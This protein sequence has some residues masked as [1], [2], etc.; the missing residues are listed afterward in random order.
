MDYQ[1]TSVLI[2][3]DPLDRR[4]DLV[5]YL[6]LL[7]SF[8]WIIA[9]GVAIGGALGF[10]YTR[11]TPATYE[12]TARLLI[13]QLVGAAVTVD[14]QNKYLALVD[15]PT[16]AAQVVKDAALDGPPLHLTPSRLEAA[17][18]ARPGAA[19]NIILIDVRLPDADAAARA[20]A[21]A[22]RRVAELAREQ[23]RNATTDSQTAIRAELAEADRL[24][25]V[26]R[27][28]LVTFRQTNNAVEMA[29]ADLDASTGDRKKLQELLGEQAANRARLEDAERQ[30]AQTQ[31]TITLRRP[32]VTGDGREVAGA[33]Q[34]NVEVVNPAYSA[35]H[36]RVQQLRDEIAGG[37]ARIAYLKGSTP[38]T[39][40]RGAQIASVSEYETKLAQLQGEVARAQRFRDQL[41]DASFQLLRESILP[42]YALRFVEETLPPGRKVSPITRNYVASGMAAGLIVSI[43]MVL[44][45]ASRRGPSSQ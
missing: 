10:V 5:G 21:S 26:A 14:V 33:P 8:A 45:L 20:A 9:I 37:D 15:D 29:R 30:L 22:G 32:V 13:G 43:V 12:A 4:I 44:A 38:S 7:R 36:A 18:T 25:A 6:S 31:P 34:A 39:A 1:R 28:A 41:G 42:R 19:N 27:E 23:D 35:L 40:D 2:P 24:V 3:P 17:I 16:L 11:L